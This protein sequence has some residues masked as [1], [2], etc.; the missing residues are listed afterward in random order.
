M[1]FLDNISYFYKLELKNR[2]AKGVNGIAAN[3]LTIFK[4]LAKQHN[5]PVIITSQVYDDFIVKDKINMVGNFMQKFSKCLIEMNKE[6]KKKRLILKK[7]KEYHERWI[8]FDI[9][10]KGIIV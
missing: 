5:I 7:P 10:D 3:Q 6:Y 8:F 1:I 2:D 9:K 4:E